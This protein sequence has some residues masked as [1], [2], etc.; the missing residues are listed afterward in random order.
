MV[1]Y[2]FQALGINDLMIP[3]FDGEALESFLLTVEKIE[4]EWRASHGIEN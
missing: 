4:T 3:L 2:I 1:Q